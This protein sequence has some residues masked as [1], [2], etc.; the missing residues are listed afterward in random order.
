M[1][2]EF[3]SIVILAVFLT[4]LASVKINENLEKVTLS[5]VSKLT[6]LK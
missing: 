4:K 5:E 1:Y 3:I 6:G 2:S